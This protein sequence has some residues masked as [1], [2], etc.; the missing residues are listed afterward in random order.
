[1]PKYSQGTVIPVVASTCFKHDDGLY[2]MLHTFQGDVAYFRWSGASK[3]SSSFAVNPL[4][5]SS[6]AM[7][8]P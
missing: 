2:G 4:P 3:Q 5:T 1:M 8:A 6:V 7:S